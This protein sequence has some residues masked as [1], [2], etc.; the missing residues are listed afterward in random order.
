MRDVEEMVGDSDLRARASAIRNRARQM[1]IEMKRHGEQPQW[2]LVEKLVAEP[3][4]ELRRDVR[5][6]L[7][8]RTAEKNELVPI[9]R[10]PVPTEFSEAVR[11]YYEQL[12]AAG[13]SLDAAETQ[14]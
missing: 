4:R 11:R 7:L 9:D 10:D 1:R 3:L 5:A 6:E 8:R 12:G 2:E 14:P 13:A